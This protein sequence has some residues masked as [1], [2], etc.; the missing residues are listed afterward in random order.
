MGRKI[1]G[2]VFWKCLLPGPGSGSA[3]GVGQLDC[4][5]ETLKSL[6]MTFVVVPQVCEAEEEHHAESPLD[7]HGT[8]PQ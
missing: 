7:R 6:E 5:S 2:A 4:V 3:A 8:G 1:Q